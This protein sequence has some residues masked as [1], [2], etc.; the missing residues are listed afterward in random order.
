M[1][2]L[3]VPKANWV[4]HTVVFSRTKDRGSLVKVGRIIE[5][6]NKMWLG[7]YWEKT[8]F[9]KKIKKKLYEN[10]LVRS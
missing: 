3:C 4:T 1:E 10:R 2:R 9:K 6:R 7:K 5:S 8:E